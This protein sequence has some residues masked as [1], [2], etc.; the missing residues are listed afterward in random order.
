MMVFF[1]E[2]IDYLSLSATDHC[3][4]IQQYRLPVEFHDFTA[5]DHCLTYTE[6]GPLPDI[7]GD[8]TCHSAFI[9]LWMRLPHPIGGGQ[10]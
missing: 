8:Y 2:N 9:G 7:H 5:L 1:S 6:I 10:L 3:N 4:L